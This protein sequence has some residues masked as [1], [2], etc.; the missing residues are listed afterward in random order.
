MARS[1]RDGDT[2][3]E[4]VFLLLVALACGVVLWVWR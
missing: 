3:D 1:R 2:A 4:V